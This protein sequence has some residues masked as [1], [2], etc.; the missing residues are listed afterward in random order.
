[1]NHPLRLQ[2]FGSFVGPQNTDSGNPSAS[3]NRLPKW[4]II[5]FLIATA[6]VF[7]DGVALLVAP[8]FVDANVE[9]ALIVLLLVAMATVAVVVVSAAKT[10]WQ[11]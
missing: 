5:A 8:L 3:R 9:F 2:R 6:A 11:K 1:M 7:L 10:R 4:Q